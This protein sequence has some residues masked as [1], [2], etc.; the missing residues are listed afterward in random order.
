[1][2]G[3]VFVALLMACL[4]GAVL[5]FLFYN[6]NPARIFM[7][8]SGSYFLGFVLAT[9]SLAGSLQKASTAVSLLVPVVALGVP[10]FD[11]LFSMIR[12]VLERRSIFSPDR[13]HIHHRLLDMG[14]THRRAVLIL[15]GS[16]VVLMAAAIGIALGRDWEVGAALVGAAA[17]M[18]GLVRL[19]GF[20]GVVREGRRRQLRQYDGHTQRLRVLAPDFLR[21]GEARSEADLWDELARL[22]Q[23]AQWSEVSISQGERTKTIWK[24]VAPEHAPRTPIAASFPLGHEDLASSTITFAWASEVEDVT[25][26]NEIMLQLVADCVTKTLTAINSDL[27][28][29]T[30]MDTETMVVGAHVAPVDS[31]S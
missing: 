8:D 6:F 2:S 26:Q 27:A 30:P 31:P 18:L 22:A 25:R 12:R 4:I 10:I 19:A 29:L 1:M 21:L 11:T 28:P 7:G 3:S 23:K 5:G 24:A 9:S 14:I 15:Y 16:S 13:G 20:F 17:V